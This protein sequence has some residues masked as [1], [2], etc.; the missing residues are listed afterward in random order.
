MLR[1]FIRAKLEESEATKAKPKPV[2]KSKWVLR[3]P[4]SEDED[5]EEVDEDYDGGEEDETF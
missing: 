2:G 1:S 4:Q 3:K 5:D